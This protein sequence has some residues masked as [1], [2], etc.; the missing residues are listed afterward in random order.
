[1]DSKIAAGSSKVNPG[2]WTPSHEVTVEQPFK[3]VARSVKSAEGRR[4][5]QRTKRLQPMLADVTK[6]ATSRICVVLTLQSLGQGHQSDL[7]GVPSRWR[8]HFE[9]CVVF[10]CQKLRFRV[11]IVEKVD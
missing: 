2:I 6:E 1:M 9:R 11:P 5:T 3:I 4:H 8:S 7:E 10:N